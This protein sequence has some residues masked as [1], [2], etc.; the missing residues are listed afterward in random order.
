MSPSAD[1]NLLFGIL[2]LQMDFIT[3]GQLIAGMQAWVLAKEQPLAEHLAATGALRPEH[4]L[5]LEPLVEA[6]IRQHG[7]DPQ[8]SLAA[9]SSVGSLPDEL[10]KLQDGQLAASLGHVAVSRAADPSVD[11]LATLP[12]P[13]KTASDP[14]TRFRIL[15]PHAEG[16]LGRVLVAE[17]GELHREVALKEIRP[18]YA[19]DSDSRARFM[20][21]AEITGGLEHPGIVPVYS[22]G[23]Y[24]DGSPFYAMRFIRGK[25]L[26]EAIEKFHRTG[27]SAGKATNSTER[28]LE[29]RRLLQR[30]IDVCQAI[31][32]AHS[33]GVLHRD[34]KPGN[35]ML[36]KYGETLVVDWGLAKALR[37]TNGQPTSD[38]SD[39][40]SSQ[41]LLPDPP[42]LPSSEPGSAPTQMGSAVGT[43][44][45]MSPEQAQGRLDQ[46]GPASDVFSLGATLY[47]ILTG[48]PPYRGGDVLGKARTADYQQPRSLN[49]FVPKPLEAICLKAM[50]AQAS[51]R[52]QTS[53]ELAQDLE[54][55]LADE[56]VSSFAEWPVSR[57]ARWFRK[58]RTLAA[59]MAACLA[60]FAIGALLSAITINEQRKLA[61]TARQREAAR[62]EAEAR[63]RRRAEVAEATASTNE[64]KAVAERDRAQQERR[65]AQAL[66]GFLRRRPLTQSTRD[67]IAL[68]YEAMEKAE[69]ESPTATSVDPKAILDAAREDAREE[70]FEDA[71]VK[72]VWFHENALKYGSGLTGV[73]LSYAL[74]DWKRLAERYPPALATLKETRDRAATHVKVGINVIESFHEF[75][76]I[77]RTLGAYEK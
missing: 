19:G 2:A 15:R 21:E 32:Y 7:N 57:A 31:H 12:L 43:P 16:G 36:G 65:T 13:P 38:S 55:F 71:L 72:H 42:L 75:E 41:I 30:L 18:E 29:L 68:A 54:R 34:L 22:L 51:Q 67:D 24:P 45:F 23:T 37:Q 9:I 27:P 26:K 17:D 44:A 73:R 47:E 28:N 20:L 59:T 5:L 70:R 48:Q 11:P 76:S 77:N 46:L 61:E 39:S 50:A 1:R 56:P 62:A 25:S 33:R 4:R 69:A 8:Q 35:I 3:K 63:E 60:L 40:T 52:Y 10:A 66:L 64:K 6:H 74:A 49:R 14:Q 58:N 53:G